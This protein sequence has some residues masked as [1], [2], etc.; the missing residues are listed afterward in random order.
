MSVE[1]WPYALQLCAVSGPPII[2]RGNH[3]NRGHAR[4]VGEGVHEADVEVT[5]LHDGALYKSRCPRARKG[6][7]SPVRR[8]PA[9]CRNV[10][11]FRFRRRRVGGSSLL[12]L[13]RRAET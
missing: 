3:E 5:A 2:L 6:V 11:G 8:R 10:C 9:L 13:G 7:L 1:M 12:L 4:W